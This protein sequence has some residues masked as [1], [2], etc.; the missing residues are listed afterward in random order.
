LGK[1]Q[2]RRNSGGGFDQNIGVAGVVY[3]LSND[4][5]KEGYYKI[6]CSRRS[7][8]ARAFSLNADANTGTPGSFKCVFEQRTVDCGRA[9]RLVFERL[10]KHRRG[11]FG[12]EFFEVELDLARQTILSVCADVDSTYVAPPPP[13]PRL[14]PPAAATSTTVRPPLGRSLGSPGIWLLGLI[15]LV[16]FVLRAQ[17]PSSKPTAVGPS[18]SPTRS[19]ATLPKPATAQTGE[20]Q[21]TRDELD[22]IEAVCGDAKQAW[23]PAAYSECTQEHRKSLLGSEPP[24]SLAA[25]DRKDL[26]LIQAACWN[27]KNRLGPQA[28]GDCLREHLRLSASERS[29]TR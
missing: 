10:R 15:V 19:S 27:A 9:E 24:P 2:Y 25:L 4:G 26:A 5:F 29:G 22:S 11:K 23:G 1:W 16:L 14:T 12:Q 21:P 8:Y 7:G 3:I 18:T 13:A 17:E 20:R 6:G 28:Y